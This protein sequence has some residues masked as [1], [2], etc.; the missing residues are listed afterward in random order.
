M[1]FKIHPFYWVNI[2]SSPFLSRQNIHPLLSGQNSKFTLFYWVKLK[3]NF[4]FSS[5]EDKDKEAIKAAI[6]AQ[7]NNVVEGDESEGDEEDEDDNSEFGKNTNAENV[8]KAAVEQ[9]ERCRIA[10]AE[11]KEKD[12][13]DREKQKKDQEER[14]KKAQEKAAKGERKR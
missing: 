10:A 4:D 9:R 1:K 8:A 3:I 5:K 2:R 12:K 11:K 7:Y 6:L 13:S 14:K